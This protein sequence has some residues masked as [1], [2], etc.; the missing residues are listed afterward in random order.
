MYIG[1]AGLYVG[2]SVRG[3]MPTLPHGPDVTWRNGRGCPL[4]VHYR[5]DLQSVQ[6]FVAMTT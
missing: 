1:H 5:A 4:V 3:R 2:A 6:G